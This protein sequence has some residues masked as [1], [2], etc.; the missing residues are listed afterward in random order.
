MG[1]EAL[2]SGE[3]EKE[4]EEGKVMAAASRPSK[5]TVSELLGSR[6]LR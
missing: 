1:K 6:V 5:P 4:E 2:L 3:G